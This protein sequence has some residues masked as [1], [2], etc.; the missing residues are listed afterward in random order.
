MARKKVKNGEKSSSGRSLLFYEPYF[1]ACL[2]FPSP[3]T[4]DLPL[5]LRG[6][7]ELRNAPRPQKETSVT[8][9]IRTC[10]RVQTGKR[11]H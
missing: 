11:A 8:I 1:P 2:D 4:H 10:Q 9:E 5:G 3:H 7:P 6:W